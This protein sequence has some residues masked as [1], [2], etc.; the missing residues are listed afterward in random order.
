VRRV[1]APYLAGATAGPYSTQPAI[2]WFGQVDNTSN[3][4]D[5]RI[6]YTDNELRIFVH[7]MDRRLWYDTAPTPATLTDWD[8]VTLYLNLDGAAGQAP[9]SDAYQFVTQLNHGQPRDNYQAAYRGNGSGW[10]AVTIPFRHPPCG[11]ASGLITARMIAAGTPVL[12]SLLPAWDCQ[13]R[14]HPAPSG[15]WPSWSTTG[16]TQPAHQFPIH[17]GRKP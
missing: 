10:N 7:I 16:M 3:Y 13:M 15:A 2:F 11:A 14:R 4:A 12:S 6:L 5:G 17:S 9:G 1:N 8:A